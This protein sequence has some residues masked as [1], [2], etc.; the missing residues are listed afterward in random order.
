LVGG[1]VRFGSG[2]RRGGERE[3][4]G[5]GGEEGMEDRRTSDPLS[6]SIAHTRSTFSLLKNS[7]MLS[8]LAVLVSGEVMN[9]ASDGIEV[10]VTSGLS[11]L[12]CGNAASTL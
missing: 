6:K 10:M 9:G 3:Q 4:E 5:R 12:I 11:D 7:S 1:W 8:A 2:W